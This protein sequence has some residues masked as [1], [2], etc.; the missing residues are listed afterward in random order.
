MWENFLKAFASSFHFSGDMT[1]KP[2]DSVRLK[3]QH[4]VSLI[5]LNARSCSGLTVL[6][7]FLYAKASETMGGKWSLVSMQFSLFPGN[8]PEKKCDCCQHSSFLSSPCCSWKLCC[9]SSQN[10]VSQDRAKVERE[11]PVWLRTVQTRGYILSQAPRHLELQKTR[12]ECEDGSVTDD[13]AYTQDLELW[14]MCIYFLEYRV[15]LL[16]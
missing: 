3:N 9:C 16:L 14:V 15:C 6:S 12:R 8:I 5:I 13:W 2:K 10:G 11:G 1:D 7:F 4:Q